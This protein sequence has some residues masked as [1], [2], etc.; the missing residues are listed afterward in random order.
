ML[1]SS[2]MLFVVDLLCSRKKK[3]LLWQE[4]LF[5]TRSACFMFI[6]FLLRDVLGYTVV[7][8]ESLPPVHW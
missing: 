6:K 2:L 8:L 5:Y 1:Q 4:L 7:A 3:D